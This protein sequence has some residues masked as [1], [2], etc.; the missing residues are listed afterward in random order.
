MVNGESNTASSTIRI[1]SGAF[2]HQRI[3]VV[4]NQTVDGDRW[5]VDLDQRGERVAG[6]DAFGHRRLR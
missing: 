5:V 3:P 2:E 6:W 1:A 4:A